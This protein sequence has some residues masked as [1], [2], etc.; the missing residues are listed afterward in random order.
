MFM[1]ALRNRRSST[2][3][4][5]GQVEETELVEGNYKPCAEAARQTA[6]RISKLISVNN[7]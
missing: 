3:V 6:V 1:S 5:V 7:D 4:R 2:V